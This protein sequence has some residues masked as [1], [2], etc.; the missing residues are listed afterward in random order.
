M[1]FKILDVEEDMLSQFNDN[2]ELKGL[3]HIL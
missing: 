3:A 2:I 1:G